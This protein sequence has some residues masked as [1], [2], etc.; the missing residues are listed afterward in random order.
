MTRLADIPV[1]LC[2]Y[3][4]YG[5]INYAVSNS[6]YMVSSDRMTCT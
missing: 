2:I 5:L 6:E 3:L 4:I 1:V